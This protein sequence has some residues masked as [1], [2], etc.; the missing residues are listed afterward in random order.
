MEVLRA[1]AGGAAGPERGVGIHALAG[2]GAGQQL[3]HDL[4][5]LEAGHDLLDAYQ[6]DQSTGQ[7]EAHAAIALG[8]NHGYRA[9]FSDQ[10]IGAAD[11]GGD[12]QKLLAKIGAGGVGQFPGIAGEVFEAHGTGKDL[13]HLAAIDV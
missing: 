4:K 10:E 12:G 5:V 7:R 1:V 11:G 9:G 13:T 3:K 2:G 6:A 8:L